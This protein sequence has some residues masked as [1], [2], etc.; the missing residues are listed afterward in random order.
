MLDE[1]LWRMSEPPEQARLDSLH[2]C[3]ASAFG[4]LDA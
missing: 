1:V 3:A 2:T 4:R